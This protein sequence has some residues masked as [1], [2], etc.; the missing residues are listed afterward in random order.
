MTDEAAEEGDESLRVA[1]WVREDWLG[2][3]GV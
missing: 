1:G 3:G 2:G